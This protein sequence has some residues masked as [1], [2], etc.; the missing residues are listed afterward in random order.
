MTSK[1]ATTPA[2]RQAALDESK[3]ILALENMV[4]PAGHAQLRKDIV[5][6]MLSIPDAVQKIL[7]EAKARRDASS[8]P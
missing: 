7:E 8:A 1:N 3:A 4:E 2:E 6:G 5:D